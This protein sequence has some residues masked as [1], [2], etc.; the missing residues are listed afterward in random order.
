L[1]TYYS[2]GFTFKE[3]V[4]Y[5]NFVRDVYT[6]FFKMEYSFKSG[7][8]PHKN[9][10]LHEIINWNQKLLEK[11]FTLGFKHHV[12]NGCMQML[13]NSHLFDEIRCFWMYDDKEFTL[14]LIVPENNILED[15][16]KFNES[17][18]NE[19]I[20]L[21]ESLWNTGL[22][23]IIQTNLE[24]DVSKSL[25]NIELGYVPSIHP[26]CIVGNDMFSKFSNKLIGSY[27]IRNMTADSIFIK[28]SS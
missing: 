5:P 19:I 14:F 24:D 17:K 10:T 21:S 11:K 23:T 8:W 26:F 3:S 4:M 18:V 2:V 27:E 6:S 12:K 1:P 13:F 9:A 7:F 20:L 28:V 22:V 16:N 25:S 15:N